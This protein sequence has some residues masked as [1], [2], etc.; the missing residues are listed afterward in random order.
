[1]QTPHYQ[2]RTRPEDGL[3]DVIIEFVCW[4]NSFNITKIFEIYWSDPDGYSQHGPEQMTK[5]WNLS[6]FSN[7]QLEKMTEIVN[8]E[9]KNY[10]GWQKWALEGLENKM[11]PIIDGTK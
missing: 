3:Y 2:I 1:M 10:A 8:E 6:H 7:E 4:Q 9:W 5:N 11:L